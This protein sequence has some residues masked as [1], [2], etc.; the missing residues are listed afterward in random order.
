MYARIKNGKVAEL[1]GLDPAV[2]FPATAS[3]W[4]PC[5]DDTQV[6]AEYSEADQVFTA[7]PYERPYNIN[8]DGSINPDAVAPTVE[9]GPTPI[10]NPILFPEEYAAA[11]AAQSE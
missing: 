8:E 3:A 4:V 7:V 2:Y 10:P 5:P 11:I 6:H 9:G 1:T